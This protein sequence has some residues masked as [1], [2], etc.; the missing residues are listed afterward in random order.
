MQIFK[1]LLVLLV[2]TSI[3]VA[4]KNDAQKANAISDIQSTQN[5]GEN[6]S[7]LDKIDQTVKTI[8]AIAEKD[9]GNIKKKELMMSSEGGEW[10]EYYDKNNKLRKALA[11]IY[12]EMGKMNEIYYFDEAGNMIQYLYK[13]YEYS[14]HLN[15]SAIMED[16]GE[17]VADDFEIKIV[18]STIYKAYLSEGKLLEMKA[19]YGKNIDQEMLDKAASAIAED[20]KTY[21]NAE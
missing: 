11:D 8:D 3:L 10:Q 12:G 20:F 9:W 13:S 17:P 16:L 15:H 18:D 1:F 5:A 2:S 19:L 14:H 6:L 4:C 21:Q 7:P